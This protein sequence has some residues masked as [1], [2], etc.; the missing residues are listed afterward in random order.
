MLLQR[1]VVPRRCALFLL[2]L[3]ACSSSP[4]SQPVCTPMPQP[5]FIVV[6][7]NMDGSAL[8]PDTS[9]T[10]SYDGSQQETFNLAST[11]P[12]PRNVFCSVV[13]PGEDPDGG[14]VDASVL[15]G[16]IAGPL[17][18]IVCRCWTDGA[19]NVE[20]DAMGLP[21][22]TETLEATYDSCNRITTVV[23]VAQLAP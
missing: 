4:Q 1:S 19:A 15:D 10:V 23:V 21:A 11:P 20:V 5:T 16:G 7:R 14:G 3:G 18:E 12:T 17:Q 6:V 22:F 13:S 2:L 9:I 8:A